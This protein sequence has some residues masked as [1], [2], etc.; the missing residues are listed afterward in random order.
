MVQGLGTMDMIG[1]FAPFTIYII[2]LVVY[3]VWEG[4]R[5]RRLRDQYYTRESRES[6]AES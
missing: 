5:E 1:L 3:Y 2:G 4:K 6:E